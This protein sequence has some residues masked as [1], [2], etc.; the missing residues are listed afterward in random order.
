MLGVLLGLA[1]GGPSDSVGDWQGLERGEE[2]GE[3][4]RQEPAPSCKC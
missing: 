1:G 2:A 3:V 4:P